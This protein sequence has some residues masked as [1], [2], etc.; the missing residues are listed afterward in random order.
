MKCL[1]ESRQSL[2]LFL[3]LKLRMSELYWLNNH[4]NVT[5][6]LYVFFSVYRKKMLFIDQTN[7]NKPCNWT[8]M[9]HVC[10]ANFKLAQQFFL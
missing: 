10:E 2:C 3:E 9:N 4:K 7:S 5:C 1:V 8:F 6:Y